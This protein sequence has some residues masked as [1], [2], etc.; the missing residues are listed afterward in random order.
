MREIERAND[1][2]G[3][4]LM[5]LQTRCLCA[6][7]SRNSL[8]NRR[9]YVVQSEDTSFIQNTLDY[10]SSS[11]FSL[12]VLLL[13]VLLLLVL[14]PFRSFSQI[15][16]RNRDVSVYQCWLLFIG[17]CVMSSAR[18]CVNSLERIISSVIASYCVYVRVCHCIFSHVDVVLCQ[19]I[20]SLLSIPYLLFIIIII[21]DI[22]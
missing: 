14:L 5:D 13:F 16:N 15:E 21:I 11:S 3:R 17:F 19:S 18:R 20:N 4:R 1:I 6:H 7:A 8:R 10:S 2:R 9:E 12:L 22:S